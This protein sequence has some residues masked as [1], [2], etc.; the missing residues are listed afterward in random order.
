[1]AIFCSGYK[2]AEYLACLYK[3]VFSDIGI[4]Y[5]NKNQTSTHTL[6]E[7]KK[8]GGVL[9]ATRDYGTGVT[10][11]GELLENIFILRLPYPITSNYK[12][13][14][15]KKQSVNTF[16]SS[17]KNE[18]LITLMQWLGRLQ[19]TAED[20]G[21]IHLMD[22]RYFSSPSL[23]KKIDDILKYYGDIKT[24]S[25]SKNKSKAVDIIKTSERENAITELDSLFGL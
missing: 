20:E 7:F 15:L 5:A 13:K 22:K 10:L 6:A 1:V 2:E 11:K 18:M 17:I 3:K 12:W 16:L 25:K 23:K 8:S 19:R 14:M 9:F 24:D 21:T 4:H